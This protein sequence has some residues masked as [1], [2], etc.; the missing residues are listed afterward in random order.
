MIAHNV[1]AI[2]HGAPRLSY[3]DAQEIARRAAADRDGWTVLVDLEGTT[4][5]TTAA[6]ARLVVLRRDLRKCGREL[7]LLGP[8]GKAKHLFDVCRLGELLP[9]QP[10][11]NA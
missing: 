2:R 7:H 11:A 5:T 10:P 6:L 1:V 4:E 3:H 9:Q 8:C